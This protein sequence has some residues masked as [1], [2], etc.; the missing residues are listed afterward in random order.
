MQFLG[1]EKYFI[2]VLYIFFVILLFFFVSFCPRVLRSFSVGER[3]KRRVVQLDAKEFLQWPEHAFFS[4]MVC[5]ESERC[6]MYSKMCHTCGRVGQ[7]CFW[8]A[9]IHTDRAVR[10]EKKKITGRR[11]LCTLQC[12]RRTFDRICDTIMCHNLQIMRRGPFV[13]PLVCC[14]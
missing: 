1:Q 2:A 11:P 7:Y 13:K 4:L 5:Q 9:L 14:P 10:T 3:G 12:M 6:L 8:Q